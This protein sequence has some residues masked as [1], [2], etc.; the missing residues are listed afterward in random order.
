ML[1]C[2]IWKDSRWLAV[3]ASII[4]DRSVMMYSLFVQLKTKSAMIQHQ[5][6]NDKNS[7]GCKDQL[8]WCLQ[9]KASEFYTTIVSRD[10]DIDYFELIRKLEKRFNFVDLPETL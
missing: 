9:G 6:P 3:I 7:T 1:M 4:N 8:C 2:F 10:F 5:K